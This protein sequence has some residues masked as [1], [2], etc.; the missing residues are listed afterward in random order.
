[1]HMTNRKFGYLLLCLAPAL[2]AACG[3]GG[4]GGTAAGTATVRSAYVANYGNGTISQYTIDATTGALAA[5][6]PATVASV[7][8]NTS[9][10][11]A[12][13][14][15]DPSGK[16]VYVANSGDQVISQFTIGPGGA[17][18][19]MN[20][21]TVNSGAGGTGSNSIVI[22]PTGKFAYAANISDNSVSLFTIGASGGLVFQST[23]PSVAAA[24]WPGPVSVAVD[25]AGK[26]VYVVNRSDKS[27]SQYTIGSGGTLSPMVPATVGTGTDPVFITIDSSGKYAY[28]AN[29]GDGT[30]SLYNIGS[31]G[32]LSPMSP[33]T[34]G[35]TG[36]SLSLPTSIVVNPSGT[37]A[38]VSNGSG[39]F[40]Y[41][42]VNG[43]L[44]D[45]MSPNYIGTNGFTPQSIA[46]DSTGTFVYVANQGSDTISQFT[47]GT[48]GTLSTPTVISV[49]S[50][51][52]QPYS[53]ATSQ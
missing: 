41:S 27:I 45:S 51:N 47:V 38:Y 49:G 18:A 9:S 3:G 48:G 37:H 39:V 31:G 11:P 24:A 40:M 35:G 34:V 13:V 21:P 36:T 19:P 26:Y 10:L 44:T 42:I 25:P 30:I 33:A 50:T 4:G 29:Y 43:V 1:M 6:S 7:S 20:P 16:Y 14:T 53:I 2:L 23:T 28:V 52:S 22:D 32:A 15:V 12:S 8:G 46:I 5:K 17:L